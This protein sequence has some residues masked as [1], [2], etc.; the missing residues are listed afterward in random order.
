M[1]GTII[2]YHRDGCPPYGAARQW[3]SHYAAVAT[4]LAEW[5][6]LRSSYPTSE[7]CVAGDYNQNR[8]GGRWYG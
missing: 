3:E 5:Q 8:D 4:Q 6:R 2:P 7:Y 1:Y